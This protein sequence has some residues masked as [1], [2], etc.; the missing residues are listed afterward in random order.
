[1]GGRD[2]VTFL[3]RRTYA[4][5]DALLPKVRVEVAA[6]QPLA[7]KF[8]PLGLEDADFVSRAENFLQNG[9]RWRI[10]GWFCITHGLWFP[11]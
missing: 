3:E 1:M 11:S 2:V 4:S 9:S 6:N 5:R 7:V 8:D 10:R